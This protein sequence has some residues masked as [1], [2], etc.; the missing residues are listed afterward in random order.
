MTAA[1]V[2]AVYAS[3]LLEVAAEKG[4]TD[5]VVAGS[6]DLLAAIQEDANLLDLLNHPRLSRDQVKRH[7]S[8]VFC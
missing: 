8:F 1:T 4:N 7:H 2:P 6:R 3:A 5:S